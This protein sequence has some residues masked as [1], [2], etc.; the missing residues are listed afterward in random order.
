MRRIVPD[1]AYAVAGRP[2]LG[3]DQ[4]QAEAECPSGGG[5]GWVWAGGSGSRGGL[6]L[7]RPWR[8]LPSEGVELGDDGLGVGASGS[9]PPPAHDRRCS[10]S[11]W[12]GS[13]RAMRKAARPGAGRPRPRAGAPLEG[14]EAGVEPAGLGIGRAL[15]PDRVVPAVA[16]VAEVVDRPRSRVLDDVPQRR[17]RRGARAAAEL[18]VGHAPLGAAGAEGAEVA[19]G[20]AHGRPARTRWSRSRRS[21]GGPSSRRRTGAGSTSR[22]VA[23]RRAT[24]RAA[25]TRPPPPRR[26]AGEPAPGAG[27]PRAAGGGCRRCGRARSRAGPGGRR[28]PA[29]RCR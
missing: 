2:L 7:A 8:P 6:G 24:W 9:K 10:W 12:A 19:V 13:A 26:H 14:H 5:R 15:D 17:L 11:S 25:L 1:L 4:A 21:P 29:W 28:H 23:A 27:A 22:G 20:P 16:E 3:V 18:R